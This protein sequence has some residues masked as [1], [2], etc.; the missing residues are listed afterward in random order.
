MTDTG[1]REEFLMRTRLCAQKA[2]ETVSMIKKYSA[3]NQNQCLPCIYFPMLT[4]T[5]PKGLVAILHIQTEFSV[6]KQENIYNNLLN[7]TF[8]SLIH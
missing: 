6:A 4:K 8:I 1:E 7:T 3:G 2:L 5:F